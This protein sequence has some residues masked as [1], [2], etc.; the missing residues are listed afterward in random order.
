MSQLLTQKRCP[1][2]KS[3][4]TALVRL[5][6][7][8]AAI[9]APIGFAGA[10]GSQLYF[11]DDFESGDFNSD[12][13]EVTNFEVIP[14]PTGA[15]P[16]FVA[17][18]ID[19]SQEIPAHLV[20]EE[21]SL[22]P[23]TI[24][25]VF[26]YDDG[27]QDGDDHAAGLDGVLGSIGILARYSVDSF[28]SS[29]NFYIFD[30]GGITETTAIPRTV[31][32]HEF[33][34]VITSTGASAYIDGALVGSVA[35]IIAA[36]VFFIE[37]QGGDVA[38]WDDVAIP[39]ISPAILEVPLDVKPQSCPSP[40]NVE[41]PGDLP[42]AIL[43][44]GDIEVTTIDPG[45]IRLEGIAP[46][47]SA[48]ED[49]ATPFMPVTGKEDALDCTDEGP[50]GIMDLTLKFKMAEIVGAI[51]SVEDGDVLVLRLT[52]NLKEGFGGTPINGEDVVIILK[53]GKR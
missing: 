4:P 8:I 34:F 42:V 40:L 15:R 52:G 12:W 22:D 32:W 50:D 41:S 51:G 11:F 35:E 28:P 48:M 46:I 17:S 7:M 13:T 33:R 30:P 38:L 44:L 53:K 5:M 37:T 36:E 23:G 20:K 26:F 2:A 25:R 6:I 24:A 9:A 18:V 45:S 39:P 49:V 19:L 29:P 21:L 27:A 3:R 47:R 43:G 1:E 16:S 10:Q 31:G 14:D